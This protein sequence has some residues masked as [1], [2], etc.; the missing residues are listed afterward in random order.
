MFSWCHPTMAL[1]ACFGACSRPL[2]WDMRKLVSKCEGLIDTGDLDEASTYVEQIFAR[3]KDSSSGHMLLGDIV[4]K[5]KRY[6][7]AQSTLSKPAI[8]PSFF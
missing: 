4:R 7:E 5:E 8:R 6:A 3:K 1:P 2:G